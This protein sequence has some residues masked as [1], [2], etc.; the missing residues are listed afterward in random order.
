MKEEIKKEEE[1]TL[2]YDELYQN[3]NKILTNNIDLNIYN[4]NTKKSENYKLINEENEILLCK[5]EELKKIKESKEN[6]EDDIKI[7]DLYKGD[8]NDYVFYLNK[9][10]IKNN[11]L[12]NSMEFERNF[13]NSKFDNYNVEE[14]DKLY[15]EVQLK[16]PRNIIE[17]EIKK[18]PFFHGVD[19][20]V[21]IKRNI[22]L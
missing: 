10:K 22:F 4:N 6:N 11:L 13:S 2:L 5:E 12:K 20:F 15:K 9:N 1:E 14:M 21:V 18:Y 16:H 3:E 8:D 19:F 17:G 7:K